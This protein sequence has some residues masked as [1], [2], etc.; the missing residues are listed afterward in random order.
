MEIGNSAAQELGSR[1][2]AAVKPGDKPH[3]LATSE[4]RKSIVGYCD[5]ISVR[6]GETIRFFASTYRPGNYNARLVRVVNGDSLSG[7]GRFKTLPIPTPF[8]RS[9]PAHQQP[10]FTGSYV[11]IVGVA[12]ALSDLQSFS[13]VALVRPSLGKSQ[14]QFAVSRWNGPR[15]GGWAIGIDERGEGAAWLG[16]GLKHNVKLNTSRRIIPGRW[17]MIGASFDALSGE[18]R[19][20]DVL[21]DDPNFPFDLD[22]PGDPL[23]YVFGNRRLV[24]DWHPIHSGEI[25]IGAGCGEP[26]PNGIPAPEGAF[27]GKIDGV[28]VVSKALGILEMVGLAT[29][30]SS[31]AAKQSG[32]LASWDFSIG[33]GTD[34]VHDVSPSKMIG[35]TVNWP[36]RGMRGY[37]WKSSDNWKAAPEEFTAICCHDDDLIDADW[38]SDFS[39][40]VPDSL[41]SG[42]YAVHLQHLDTEHYVPFFI[43]PRR[44]KRMAETAFVIPSPTYLA[45]NNQAKF[46]TQIERYPAYLYNVDD[47]T[48]FMDH[49]EFGRSIYDNHTDGTP[50]QISSWLRPSF[51]ITL[52]SFLHLV[53]ADSEAVDWLEHID[54]PYDIITEDMIHR[55][56]A[57]IVKGYKVLITGQHPEYNSAHTQDVLSEYMSRGGRMMYLGGNGFT[58]TIAW[59]PE[60]P[61][62]EVRKPNLDWTSPIWLSGES[63]LM[64]F[65]GTSCRPTEKW[66]ARELGVSFQGDIYAVYYMTGSTYYR[67][68]PDADS[69]RVQFIFEGVENRNVIGNYGTHFGG[70]AG[71]E[72]DAFAPLLGAPPHALHLARS[73]GIPAPYWAGQNTSRIYEKINSNPESHAYASIVFFETSSGGAVFSVGSLAWSGALSYNGFDNDVCRMTTNVLRRFLD[74]ASFEVPNP[75][76]TR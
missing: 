8:E 42:I 34:Q 30:P 44:G 11:R 47:M 43:A 71:D 72:V 59:H 46:F 76:N 31:E 56:G 35:Q 40:L 1:V 64:E 18:F 22:R 26:M 65:D 68:L 23:H 54:I 51:T 2:G 37:H 38:E 60:L 14:P 9:Y 12:N 20:Y 69:P 45:Y 75:K 29:T 41:K 61:I 57:D 62:I 24:S 63:T 19:V 66:P 73:E 15:Q 21:L 28:R 74:P 52:K 13:V 39:Y 67:A 25:R 5:R 4:A 32:V 49:P 33:I 17:T 70:A 48:F 7:A 6:P 27:N 3:P 55:E 10:I 36:Q 58:T 53:T 16:D 50:I